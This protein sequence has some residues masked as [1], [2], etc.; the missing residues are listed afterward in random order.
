L[1]VIVGLKVDPKKILAALRSIG[2]KKRNLPLNGVNDNVES[3]SNVNVPHSRSSDPTV[4]AANDL[5][6]ELGINKRI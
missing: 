6:K 3:R 5:Y 2:N 4:N 1:P